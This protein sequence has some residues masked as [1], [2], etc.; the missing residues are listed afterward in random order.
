[1]EKKQ[2]ALLF[3]KIKSY[4][5]NNHGIP[6]HKA[7]PEDYREYATAWYEMIGHQDY[8]ETFNKL[9]QHAR[10]SEFP[11]KIIH[12]TVEKTYKKNAADEI[13]GWLLEEE[14]I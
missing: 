1:M 13:R 12:L 2:L 8:E 5:R 7:E 4:Y 10:R 6:C 11:P 14:E 3:T 9:K